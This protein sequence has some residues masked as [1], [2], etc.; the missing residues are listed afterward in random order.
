MI[1]VTWEQE[2]YDGRR[3]IL[4]KKFFDER[5]FEEWKSEMKKAAW[6]L[7]KL[8]NILSVESS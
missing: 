1:K 8:F 4:H 6:E 3:I 7:G 5:D 2:D